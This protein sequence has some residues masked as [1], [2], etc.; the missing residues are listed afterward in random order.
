[1]NIH[2]PDRDVRWEGG[3]LWVVLVMGVESE[4]VKG[5]AVKDNVHVNDGERGGVDDVVKGVGNVAHS[6]E[7]SGSNGLVR[8]EG[9]HAS[10][11]AAVG[12]TCGERRWR[13]VGERE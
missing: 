5:G 8:V 10:S 2:A 1:M 13:R 7:G 11:S 4:I 3:A 12:D 9:S 6:E